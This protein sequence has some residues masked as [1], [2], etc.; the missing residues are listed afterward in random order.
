MVRILKNYI[1]CDE[2]KSH[3]SYDKNDVYIAWNWLHTHKVHYVNCP[4]CDN[5][6]YIEQFKDEKL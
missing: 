3:L 4:K 2:C 5:D 1:Q 6:I